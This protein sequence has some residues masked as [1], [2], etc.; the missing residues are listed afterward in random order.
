MGPYV[1]HGIDKTAT[2]DEIEAAYREKQKRTERG[3]Q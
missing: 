1:I 3:V 2:R